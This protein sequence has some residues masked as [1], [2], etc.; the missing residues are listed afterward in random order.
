MKSTRHIKAEF[1]VC[2]FFISGL[3]LR[4]GWVGGLVYLFQ[5]KYYLFFCF[6]M[7]SLLR[8]GH[9]WHVLR[10]QVSPRSDALAYQQPEF[11]LGARFAQLHD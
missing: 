5:N 8:C 10:K 7:L 2:S 6:F 4:G 3:F 11:V 9:K 1:L